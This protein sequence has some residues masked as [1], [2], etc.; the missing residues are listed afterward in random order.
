MALNLKLHLH[1]EKGCHIAIEDKTGFEINDEGFEPQSEGGFIIPTEEMVPQAKNTFRLK[2]IDLYTFLIYN[3]SGRITPHIVNTLARHYEDGPYEK[4]DSNG[5][6]VWIDKPYT[7][8]YECL[9][10]PVQMAL[11]VDGWYSVVN[12]TAPT[13]DWVID[14]LSKWMII[15]EPQNLFPPVPAPPPVHPP[16]VADPVILYYFGNIKGDVRAVREVVY[17][18]GTAAEVHFFDNASMDGIEFIFNSDYEDSL[19]HLYTNYDPGIQFGKSGWDSQDD[20]VYPGKYSDGCK[21]T[22]HHCSHSGGCYGGN[23]FA[24]DKDY[25]YTRGPKGEY[26]HFDAI[27]SGLFY[28]VMNDDLYHIN[29]MWATPV[30]PEMDGYIADDAIPQYWTLHVQTV[31]ACEL[32]ML[33]FLKNT[34]LHKTQGDFITICNLMDCWLGLSKQL[35]AASGP[36][37]SPWDENKHLRYR[38]DVVKMSIDVIGYMAEHICD[39]DYSEVQKTIESLAYCG[40]CTGLDMPKARSCNCFK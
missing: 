12:M 4:I 3:E 27:R 20:T 22:A 40:L 5:N 39:G 26:G 28:S 35:M 24:K 11:S 18:E 36:C 30:Y 34:T 2:D 31:D 17:Y 32:L 33:Q 21:K 9:V 19:L 37:L 23:V 29:Y 8:T 13:S 1:N 25:N 15:R 10:R 16:I 6:P 14:A 7:K 38:R